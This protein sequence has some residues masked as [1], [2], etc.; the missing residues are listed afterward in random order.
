MFHVKVSVLMS[1]SR[2][3]VCGYV[4][5]GCFNSKFQYLWLFQESGLWVCFFGCFKLKCQYLWVVQEFWFVGIYFLDVSSQSFNLYEFFQEFWFVGMF[6]LD[7]SS[8]FQSVWLFQEFWFVGLLNFDL[9]KIR[10]SLVE[11]LN[12]RLYIPWLFIWI[13]N[14]LVVSFVWDAILFTWSAFWYFIWNSFI[15]DAM[16]SWLRSS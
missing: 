10:W 9:L 2:I 3:Q 4:V 7:V 5:F 14:F 8:Q 11:H 15:D 1:F 12:C 6:F 13:S 16:N